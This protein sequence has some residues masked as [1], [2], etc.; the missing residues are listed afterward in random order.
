M[1]D[2]LSK[3]LVLTLL[4]PRT[5]DTVAASSETSPPY[6]VS[7]CRS[8]VACTAA[9]C[10]ADTRLGMRN[11]S[12]G[13]TCFRLAERDVARVC[14]PRQRRVISVV[15]ASANAPFIGIKIDQEKGW[16]IKWTSHFC[17]LPL[18]S[19]NPGLYNLIYTCMLK[20]R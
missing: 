9:D 13:S 19:S 3:S 6:G 4:S 2:A 14:Y 5:P 12:R 8:E 7:V 20:L 1:H 11:D 15:V 16:G 17:K 10:R 18:Y